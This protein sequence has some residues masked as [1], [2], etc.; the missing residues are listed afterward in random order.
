MTPRD[1]PPPALARILIHLLL[2][3]QLLNGGPETIPLGDEPFPR[4][5]LCERK[6]DALEAPSDR[7]VDRP[8]G[9]ANHAG[10]RPRQLA[11]GTDVVAQLH[12]LRHRC[13]HD[14]GCVPQQV[15]A[16]TQRGVDVL[17]AVD[18]PEV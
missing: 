8:K 12:P 5:G 9:T 2:L 10:D 6:P 17:V 7:S 15:R 11:L 14:R 3:A 4:G 18:V 13:L 1:P 16:Q